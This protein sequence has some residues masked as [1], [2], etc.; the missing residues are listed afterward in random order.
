MTT[1]DYLRAIYYVSCTTTNILY[2]MLVSTTYQVLLIVMYLFF[3]YL[4]F[5]MHSVLSVYC[6]MYW[7]SA[8][9]YYLCVIY[10]SR[11]FPSLFSTKDFLFIVFNVLTIT[12]I[13]FTII[14]IITITTIITTV[15]IAIIIPHQ[16]FRFGAMIFDSCAPEQDLGSFASERTGFLK[17]L[18]RSDVF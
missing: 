14:E 3:K 7:L 12:M 10:H 11:I 16:K 18:R 15:I 1:Y 9:V 6:P 2:T 5:R 17:T 4:S 8:L 13:I